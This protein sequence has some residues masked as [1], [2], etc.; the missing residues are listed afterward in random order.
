MAIV[1]E[2]TTKNRIWSCD[3]FLISLSLSLS[4]CFINKLNIT[5][6]IHTFSCSNSYRSKNGPTTEKG[7]ML[8]KTKAKNNFFF[9]A[10]TKD[11]L[12]KT[13]NVIRFNSELFTGN[14]RHSL[15]M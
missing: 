15:G 13:C 10:R 2:C 1:F 9:L 4:Q 7:R 3:N 5:I 14:V 6:V 8:L 11:V 12:I